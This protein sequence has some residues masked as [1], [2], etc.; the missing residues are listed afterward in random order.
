MENLLDMSTLSNCG[1]NDIVYRI[2]FYILL[3][4]EGVQGTSEIRCVTTYTNQNSFRVEEDNWV[5]M[6]NTLLFVSINVS[7]VILTNVLLI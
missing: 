6:I 5:L 1:I 3:L 7:L 2:Y 4:Y